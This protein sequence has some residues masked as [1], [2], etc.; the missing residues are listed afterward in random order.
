MIT[1]NSQESANLAILL[2]ITPSTTMILIMNTL[3]M[4]MPKRTRFGAYNRVYKNQNSL[5]LPKDAIL[6]QVRVFAYLSKMARLLEPRGMHM[7]A[8]VGYYI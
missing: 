3:T 7:Q 5:Q 2:M 8:P 6:N 1:Q 4:I